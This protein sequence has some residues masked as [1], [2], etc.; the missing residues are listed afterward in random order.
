MFRPACVL[1]GLATADPRICNPCLGVLPWNDCI[2][3]RCG[4]PQ[5]QARPDGITCA[6]CQQRLPVFIRARAPL[7]YA[8]PVDSA[9]KKLKFR[10]QLMYAP[11]FAD[12]LLT[13]I[14]TEFSECDALVPVPLHRWR[15]ITRGFNQ[16]DELARPL[17]RCT[18]LPV[19]KSVART[20]S[21]GRQGHLGTSRC[22]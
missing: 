11:A 6:A 12:L 22:S 8:F 9:L 21:K 2:C 5:I 14:T 1:C 17:S 13:V 10:R 15:H 7:R 4:Q 3:E 19:I 18:G 16:A 20:K